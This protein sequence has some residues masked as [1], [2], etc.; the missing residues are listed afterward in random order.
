LGPAGAEN[1][2][3]CG[4]HSRGAWLILV[5]PALTVHPVVFSAVLAAAAMHAG[6][7]AFLKLRLEPLLAMTLITAG[8]GL[9]GVPFLIAFG[10]PRAAAWPW[11]LASVALHFGYYLA[12]TSAY[13]RAEMSQVYPIARGGA[14]LL[15]ALISL[16]VL[17]EALSARAAAGVAVLGTGVILMSVRGHTGTGINRGAIGFALLTAVTISSYT[18]VDG[19]GARTAATP[20]PMPRRCS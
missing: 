20:A 13:R 3:A 2:L 9:I 17:P 14:P 8:A 16:L 4:R 10:A 18:L 7:N 11:L 6:W 12:L 15:T 1:E 5:T 19:I